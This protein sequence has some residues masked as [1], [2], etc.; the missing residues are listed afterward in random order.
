MISTPKTSDSAEAGPL[1]PFARF[2]GFV[3]LLSH[4]I[5]NGLNAIDLESAFIGEITTE[6][7][8]AAE[9]KKL[10]GMVSNVTH[11][12]QKLSA[13]VAE[14]RMNNVILCPVRDFLEV[15][16]ERIER[17]FSDQ[18]PE[19]VWRIETQSGG[20][21]MDFEMMIA[22]LSEIFRNAFQ[23]RAAQAPV[24]FGARAEDA[25]IVFE[26]RT[27]PTP[28]ATPP[29]TWGRELLVSTRHG[30]FGLGLFYAGRILAA[31]GGT[32]DAELE[33]ETAVTRVR[34]P[35]KTAAPPAR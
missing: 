4:E 25:Q 18:M 1:I 30:G 28:G 33:N 6:P 2:A 7:E 24:E 26:I 13:R 35:L 20:I 15:F 29:E 14:L 22:A 10:R 34:L 11:D 3:R 8:I 9:I 5:R 12:L 23:F 27:Q 32:L 31:H 21:E 17:E 16:R 19:I